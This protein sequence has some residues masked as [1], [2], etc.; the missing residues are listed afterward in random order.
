MQLDA[1]VLSAPSAR[2]G[3]AFAAPDSAVTATA[4][5]AAAPVV[6]VGAGPVGLRVAQE[7]IKR[8]PACPLVIYGEERWQPYNRVRLSSFLAGELGWSSVVTDSLPPDAENVEL[9]LGCAVLAIDRAQRTVLDAADRTQPYSHLVLATGSRP[10][11]P[12]IPGIALNGVFT[13]RSLGD[14]ERLLARRV[15]S[16]R[17]VV[18]GGGLLGLEAAR[19]MR[20]F[21][22]EVCVIEHA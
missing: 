21:N 5:S 4:P 15:R 7:L 16:R 13:F 18:L 1:A 11:V 14:A 17:T 6:I 12:L 20:R 2:E 19:A 9:R 8:D 10:Q 3:E 22:T